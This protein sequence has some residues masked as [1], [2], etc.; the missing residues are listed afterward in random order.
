[1]VFGRYPLFNPCR[2]PAQWMRSDLHEDTSVGLCSGHICFCLE[3]LLL[4]KRVFWGGCLVFVFGLVFWSFVIVSFCHNLSS[5]PIVKAPVGQKIPQKRVTGKYNSDASIPH[6][7]MYQGDCFWMG[8]TEAGEGEAGAVG[9]WG[10]GTLR[11]GE[12]ACCC[13]SPSISKWLWQ[14]LRGKMGT[15]H[16]YS[17][18]D[19]HV[20]VCSLSYQKQRGGFIPAVHFSGL[21]T[22]YNTDL[23]SPLLMNLW[24][25][26]KW[27]AR[28]PLS[29]RYKPL[30]SLGQ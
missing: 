29:G 5:R 20:C 27:D 28:S 17:L 30:E 9:D 19:P 18:I 12:E 2:T 6:E 10:R 21:P 7:F 1:M 3:N 13:W 22:F 23:T 14:V 8:Q 26:R 11:Q 16:N 15:S 25:L 24:A 4:G